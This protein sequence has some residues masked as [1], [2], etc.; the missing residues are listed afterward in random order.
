MSVM[1]AFL[2]VN[3]AIILR[4]NGSIEHIRLVLA[5]AGKFDIEDCDAFIVRCL[6]MYYS[7]TSR[8]SSSS[9]GR[10]SSSSSVKE[11]KLGVEDFIVAQ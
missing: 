1:I 7:I 8:D 2:Q 9:S 4:T 11:E 10:I 3:S 5:L 6:E